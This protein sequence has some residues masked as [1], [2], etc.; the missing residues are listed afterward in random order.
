MIY[1]LKAFGQTRTASLELF[2]N[3]ILIAIFIR[4][5]FSYDSHLLFCFF[6]F[7]FLLKTE[8]TVIKN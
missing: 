1:N 3:H 4:N 5:V 7:F 8:S 6:F 2:L